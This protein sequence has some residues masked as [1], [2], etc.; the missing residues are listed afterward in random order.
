MILGPISLVLGILP[1]RPPS[2]GAARGKRLTG[3]SLPRGRV[4][5]VPFIPLA[6]GHPPWRVELLQK[7]PA[8]R[9]MVRAVVAR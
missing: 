7:I 8:H 4:R 6:L 3:P 2:L 9:P 5:R 1:P